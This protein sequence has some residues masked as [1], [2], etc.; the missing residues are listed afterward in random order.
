MAQQAILDTGVVYSAFVR[1]DQHHETGLA[2][3]KD[4]DRGSLPQLIVLDFVLA[5]TMN[6][7]THQL[8]PP[9]PREALSMLERSTGFDIVRTTGTVWSR[10]RTVFLNRDHLSFVDALLVALARE[11]ELP[12]LYSFDTGFDDIDGVH[13]LN[14]N[15]NPYGP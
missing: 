13:R 8:V 12:Y 14:T 7:L 6:A 9:D 11:R 4:A 2:V 15:V 3:I 5:E 1:H 10:G